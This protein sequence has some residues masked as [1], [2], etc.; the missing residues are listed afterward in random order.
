[1]LRDAEVWSE[2]EDFRIV[3]RKIMKKAAEKIRETH[4]AIHLLETQSPCS[5]YSPG[6]SNVQHSTPSGS[7]DYA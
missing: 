6:G 4:D 7:V 3:E 1:L 5:E 2:E